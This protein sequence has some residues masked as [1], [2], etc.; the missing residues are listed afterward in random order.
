MVIISISRSFA[1]SPGSYNNY[2]CQYSSL[3]PDTTEQPKTSRLPPKV[4]RKVSVCDYNE[5]TRRRS[6]EQT[7]N[8]QRR[9][10]APYKISFFVIEPAAYPQSPVRN[11]GRHLPDKVG[12]EK[13]IN[14]VA[15]SLIWGP[16]TSHSEETERNE[17]KE[18]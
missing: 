16:A 2:N 17:S 10:S 5:R 13:N 6:V 12:N 11:S 1:A 18:N 15:K 7:L 8:S 9:K 4:P 3:Y 14:N